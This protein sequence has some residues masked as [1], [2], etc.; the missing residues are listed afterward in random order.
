VFVRDRGAGFDPSEVGGDRR[1]LAESIR[2]RMDRHGGTATV[3]STPGEGTEV[4]LTMP[5]DADSGSPTHES[6]TKGPTE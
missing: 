4:E 6:A 2:G 5:V 3:R 1:G